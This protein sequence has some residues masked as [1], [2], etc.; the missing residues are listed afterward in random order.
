MIRRSS[1]GETLT[2]G[3]KVLL[4]DMYT[5]TP[6]NTDTGRGEDETEKT[7]KKQKER[8]GQPRSA[9]GIMTHP[10][11]F[12][13]QFLSAFCTAK[14]VKSTLISRAGLYHIIHDN[15]GQKNLAREKKLYHDMLIL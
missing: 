13:Q 14:S 9:P 8:G 7:R 11:T 1:I 6:T 3:E 15:T 10:V 5:N 2:G 4:R 12:P